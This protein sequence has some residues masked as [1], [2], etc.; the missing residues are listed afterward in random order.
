MPDK[1]AFQELQYAFAAH[2]RDPES[3]AAPE[4]IEDRRLAVYRELFYNNVQSLLTSTFP[5][6]R[7]RWWAMARLL[8][9]PPGREI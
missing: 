9:L 4:G 7:E 5:V 2:I 1:P 3:N 6:L 8:I